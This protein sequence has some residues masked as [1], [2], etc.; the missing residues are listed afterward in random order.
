V[1]LSARRTLLAA[2]LALTLAACGSHDE[3]KVVVGARA[4]NFRVLYR[5][6]RG[7]AASARDVSWEVLSVKR[8]FLASDLTFGSRPNLH[9]LGEPVSGTLTDIDHL[10]AVDGAHVRTIAGRQPGLPT[11]D[12]ALLDVTTLAT[13]HNLARVMGTARVIGRAC[14]IVRFLEPPV[15]GLDPLRDDK[16]HDD[17][18]IARD[19]IVLRETWTLKGRVVQ[20]RVAVEITKAPDDAFDTTNAEPLPGGVA[21]PRVEP[22]RD[23]P[24]PPAPAGYTLATAVDFFFP[25]ADDATQLAYASKVWAYAK[26][27]DEITVEQGAGQVRPWSAAQETPLRLGSRQAA[28]VVRSDGIEIHWTTAQTWVRVRGATSLAALVPYALLVSNSDSSPA[29]LVPK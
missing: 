19:G 10:Y 24:G 25:R 3:P 9:S 28:Y 22:L 16:G 1:R 4:E 2:A 26:G 5:V 23:V 6:V 17:L 8:P 14:T 21:A 29:A 11:G 13:R 12:Q 7:T 27:A 18:C 20:S 15:G